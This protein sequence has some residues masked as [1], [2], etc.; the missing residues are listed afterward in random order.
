[1]WN[2]FW[3]NLFAMNFADD[4][5][6]GGGKDDDKPADDKPADDKPKDDKPAEAQFTLKVDGVE[7]TV[8]R[9]EVID[10]AQK[11]DG[12]DAKFQEAAQIRKDAL[13]G[14]RIGALFTEA[15]NGGLSAKEA[16]ELGGLIGLDTADM[17]KFMVKAGKP[18][19]KDESPAGPGKKI[20]MMDLPEEAQRAV[21][22]AR[23]AEYKEAIRV[24]TEDCKNL[25]DKDEIIVKLIDSTTVASD[26]P[27]KMAEATNMV[28]DDVQ[29]RMLSGEQYGPELVAISVQSIRARLQK[30]GTPAK[31]LEQ[32]NI[33]L[34]MGLPQPSVLPAAVQAKEP[35]KRVG[36]EDDKYD[37]N[38]LHRFQQSVV[39]SAKKL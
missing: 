5:G 2:L 37:E 3:K 7:R 22:A 18:L 33:P 28:F 15:G 9:Q 16:S 13:H 12:A 19:K 25:V 1:M 36:I 21:T 10:L 34:M 11:A 31:A 24:I 26:V 14:A 23:K 38:F 6:G 29:R 17:E 39:Q 20:A 35:I 4:G 32:P 30:F 8:T 27:S